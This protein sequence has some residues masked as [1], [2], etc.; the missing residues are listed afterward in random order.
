MLYETVSPYTMREPGGTI[1]VAGARYTAIDE[2]TVRVE[3]SRFEPADQYTVKL[4]GAAVSGYETV[5]FTGIRDPQILRS[6]DEWAEVFTK[7]LTDRVEAVLDLAPGSWGSRPAAVRLQRH[8]RRA[9]DRAGH[10]G[11][12]RG[13]AS[14]QRAGPADGDGD[15]QAG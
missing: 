10:T 4:E 15:L 5:S 7:A 3:G 11:R 12:S 6:I 1:E 14:G 13:D 2:R 8:P 9:G